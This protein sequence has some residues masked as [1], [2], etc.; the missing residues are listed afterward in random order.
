MYKRIISFII[1]PLAALSII[2]FFPADADNPRATYTL[3]I[4]MLMAAWW[5][6][7]IVPLAVTSLLPVA[8]FPLFGVLDA[9]DVSAAYFNDVIFLFM[10]GFLVA[11]AMQRWE[12][13]RRIALKIL[14]YTGAGPGR[15]LLGF[16]SATAFL[17]MW[18]SNTATAM[19]ML[20]IAMSVIGQ[21]EGTEEGQKFRYSTGLL[22]GIAYSASIGGVATLVGTPPNLSFSRIFHIYYPDAPPVS[23]SAWLIFALPFSL[24]FLALVWAFLYMLYK[25][26]KN[27]WPGISRNT[28]REQF[29]EM[30]AV[31]YEEKVILTVF[32][33]L[34]ALWIFRAD[35]NMGFLSI[36]GWSSYLPYGR[37]VQDGT[38]AIFMAL[39][40]FLVPS[41]KEKGK[42][43]LDWPTASKIP[44]QI[45]LL[46]GGGFALASGFKESGLS[47]WFGEQLRW[48]ADYP[49]ILVI[50]VIALFISFLTELTS[51]TATTEMILPILAGI[52]MQTGI[53][54]LVLML[55]ATLSASMAFMLPV[56]TPPNA[57][58]FSTGRI[59][60]S[61]MA[62][63][64]IIL[65]VIGAI[66]VTL[67]VY[68]WGQFVFGISASGLPAWA[69]PQ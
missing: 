38:V 31:S 59:H 64:G 22:L 42:K 50:L 18:I 69:V 28:F 20:P 34:A 45:L 6:T 47:V 48:V 40:L 49:L 12:L 36:K 52:A 9:R 25:P 60:T 14:S 68:Y 37:M 1:V 41:K 27:E 58:V 15:I 57:I 11:L 8:L 62:R 33:A 23:F 51:N 29:H 39:I 24:A 46:F 35:L 66:A 30:G 3:C 16:M 61:Q 21:M 54:P 4:A 13:H 65:N 53:H 7:E 5:I 2:L 44:W 19:M 26:R 67:L 56:A 10:G 17:S 43:L 63:T 55:P 32:T